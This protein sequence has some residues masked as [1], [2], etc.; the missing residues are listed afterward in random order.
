M[1]IR[2]RFA[3]DRLL[4]GQ[5]GRNRRFRFRRRPRDISGSIS[6]AGDTITRRTT[7]IWSSAASSC[8]GEARID[9]WEKKSGNVVDFSYPDRTPDYSGDEVI[10]PAKILDL[11][12][13][14]GAD[15][16]LTWDAPPGSWTILRLGHT[17]TGAKTKH[18]RPENLGLE[19]DKLSAEATRVQFTNYVG[20]I[21]HEVHHV[22]GAKLA[23]INIDSAEH[24][25]QNWTPDFEA[26]F[27]KLRGYSMHQY[28]PAMM[29]R[30]VGSREQSDKFLFDVRRTIADLMSEEYYGTFQNLC[31]AEGMT[32]M[33]EAPGIATCLPSDNIQAKGRT[34]IPMGEFWMSQ[35][36]GTM[37]C[38]ETASAAHVYGKSI[39]AA[40][41]FTGSRADAL[42]GDDEAVRRRGTGAG[43][44]PLLSCSPIFI[45][46]GTTV[47]PASRRTDFM[48]PISGTIPGGKTA[49]VSGHRLRVR[50]I[51]CVKVMPSPIF[52][53]TLATTRRS[54]LP[55]GG[56]AP[57]RPPATITMFAAMKCSSI[58]RV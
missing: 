47:S 51:S 56:C 22:P 20:V 55:P 29:G 11:T 34:D 39:A 28:L 40:E 17:P 6:T 42:S 35:P 3:G 21:L 31:H 19:S 2:L 52:C 18:G 7:T 38:K 10:D 57:C 45:N 41:S 33:A 46:H 27:E 9:Q 30:V 50:P 14:L 49:P 24:G 26:Q 37:D 36:D 58:A 44:Q 43:H 25:S 4:A 15:G 48:F 8:D 54:K 53:M 12:K 1:A 16:K 32:E 13:N 5:S 23:G